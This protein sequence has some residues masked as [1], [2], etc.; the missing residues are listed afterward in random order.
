MSNIQQIENELIETVEID[1]GAWVKIYALMSEVY[2]KEL[3]RSKHKSYTSWVGHLS[4]EV[5]LH[6]SLLWSR[7]KA[8]NV[9]SD[10][11]LRAKARGEEVPDIT[12][13]TASPDCFVLANKI[14]RGDRDIE[15]D[16][17]RK[18]V[19]GELN[20][21]ALKRTWAATKQRRD[22][23]AVH[24][25]DA[26]LT[27]ADIVNELSHRNWFERYIHASSQ[28]TYGVLPGFAV[29]PDNSG[30]DSVL[31]MGLLMMENYSEEDDERVVLHGIDIKM[32]LHSLSFE[33]KCEKYKDFVDYSWLAVP[34]E[35]LEDAKAVVDEDC[36]I[37]MIVT[38]D[39]QN[40]AYVAK[41]PER[42]KAPYREK[43]LNQA[44]LQLL[45]QQ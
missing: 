18:V 11:A 16:L 15:D 29:Y 39:N 19:S 36:G 44:L 27:I 42:N 25:P 31:E 33:R 13:V 38:V 3:W 7:L 26:P 14:A 5:Q 40:V 2:E 9:Y 4:S 35:L 37:I 8:G 45:R 6:E 20:R 43:T 21:A 10:Y 17:I 34:V 28:Q 24:R 41:K 1:K 30:A 12:Q 32:S 22:H 23:V